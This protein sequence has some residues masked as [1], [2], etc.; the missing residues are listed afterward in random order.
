M[1]RDRMAGPWKQVKGNVRKGAARG[2]DDESPLARGRRERSA[3]K[4]QHLRCPT[5]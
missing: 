3:G 5:R 1:N 4:L 2:T